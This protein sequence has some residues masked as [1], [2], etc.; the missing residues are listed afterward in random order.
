MLLSVVSVLPSTIN[1]SFFTACAKW[2]IV[3]KRFVKTQTL[4][5]WQLPLY[6]S[7]DF[8][9]A[10]LFF[11]TFVVTWSLIIGGD[12]NQEKFCILETITYF[13]LVLLDEA[14]EFLRSIP[15]SAKD[16]VYYNIQ[17]V[18]REDPVKRNLKGRGHANQVF[19]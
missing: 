18:V 17:R 13:A 10:L 2:K 1:G 8:L 3:F 5:N 12:N 15:E 6:D 7:F 16:K 19:N 11:P 14:L 9:D 4:N